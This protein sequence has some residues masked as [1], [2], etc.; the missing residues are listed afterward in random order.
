MGDRTFVSRGSV[1][2]LKTLLN[3]MVS[4]LVDEPE[5]IRIETI[6]QADSTLLRLYV[7]PA[8]VGKV[9]G[10]QGNTARS[11]RTILSAASKKL[12]HSYTL[13]II[14][15]APPIDLSRGQ[16]LERE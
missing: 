11:I 16:S 3:E 1:F 9:I 13:D 12:N 5:A 8:D 15:Y 4:V 6:A 7:A 2:V 10:K 14:E